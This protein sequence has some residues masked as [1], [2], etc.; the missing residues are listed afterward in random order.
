VELDRGSRG[1][2]HDSARARQ[3]ATS[4]IGRGD[5]S[6]SA[7]C[8]R[9]VLNGQRLDGTERLPPGRN[10]RPPRR[11]R[12][13]LGDTR[14]PQQSRH[15]ALPTGRLEIFDGAGHFPHV[16]QPQRFADLLDDFLATSTPAEIKVQSMRCQLLDHQR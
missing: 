9:R 3:I 14:R 10:T 13:G 8:G 1:P 12:S 7:R 16:E 11:G 5:R 6:R 2:V 4:D 15:H